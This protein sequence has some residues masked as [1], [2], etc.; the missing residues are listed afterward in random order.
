MSW[1]QDARSCPVDRPG[2]LANEL[3]MRGLQHG[4]ARCDKLSGGSTGSLAS[5]LRGLRDA[6]NGP[7]DRPGGFASELRDARSVSDHHEVGWEP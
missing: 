4:P 3:R 5:E 7:V 2:G 6:R 1:L